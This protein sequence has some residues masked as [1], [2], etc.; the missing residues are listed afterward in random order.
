MFIQIPSH[1]MV[2]FRENDIV[3]DFVVLRSISFSEHHAAVS[4]RLLTTGIV[5][6][7]EDGGFLRSFG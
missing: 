6:I 4:Y 5:D 7:S 3:A 1:V 2:F